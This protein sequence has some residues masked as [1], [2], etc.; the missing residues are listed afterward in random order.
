MA[1]SDINKAANDGDLLTRFTAAAAKTGIENPQ[2]W[3]EANRYRLVNQT[4]AE[5]QSISDVYA[6]AVANYQP[7]P[8]P[9]NNPAAV[10]DSYIIAAVEAVNTN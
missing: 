6:Y 2:Q 4:A 10:T 9:G 5:D 3:V 8:T 1:L 7:T